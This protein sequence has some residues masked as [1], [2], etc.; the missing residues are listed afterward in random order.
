MGRQ[1]SP[2]MSNMREIHNHNEVQ[3][4]IVKYIHLNYVNIDTYFKCVSTFVIRLSY[5]LQEVLCAYHYISWAQNTNTLRKQIIWSGMCEC[6]CGISM[7][8]YTIEIVENFEMFLGF[9]F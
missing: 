8:M 9:T 4:A 2:E 7:E 5:V 1:S 3:K 6:L